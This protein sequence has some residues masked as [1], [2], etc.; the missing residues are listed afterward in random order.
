MQ[1]SIFIYHM[2]PRQSDLFSRVKPMPTWWKPLTFFW[3]F[4]CV[5]GGTNVVAA[6]FC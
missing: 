6:H 3:K 1:C 2:Q 5:F 4:F